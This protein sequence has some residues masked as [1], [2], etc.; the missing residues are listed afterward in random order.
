MR[1]SLVL[2][3]LASDGLRSQ[4]GLSFLVETDDG[5]VMFDAGQSD[6][7]FHNLI[8]LGRDSK[9]IKAVGVSHGHYDHTGGLSEKC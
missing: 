5:S 4:H 7:W 2:D 6:E 8:A 1:V 9:A 3:N